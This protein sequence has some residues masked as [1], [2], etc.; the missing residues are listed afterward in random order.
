[1]MKSERSTFSFWN[2]CFGSMVARFLALKTWKSGRQGSFRQQNQ[3]SNQLKKASYIYAR[4]G[5]YRFSSDQ[6]KI[7]LHMVSQTIKYLLDHQFNWLPVCSGCGPSLTPTHDLKPYWKTTKIHAVAAIPYLAP[8]KMIF[9][10]KEAYPIRTSQRCS[11][12]IQPP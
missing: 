11:Q 8:N 5:S 12:I 2:C 10:N 9:F 3:P 4:G 6:W 7:L 1:M